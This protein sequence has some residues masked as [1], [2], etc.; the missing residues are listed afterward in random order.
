MVIFYTKNFDGKI[1]SAVLHLLE[2]LVLYYVV[3]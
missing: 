3:Q 2:K 1:R